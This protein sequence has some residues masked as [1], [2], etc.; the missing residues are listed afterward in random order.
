ML[1]CFCLLH[2]NISSSSGRYQLNKTGEMCFIIG[3]TIIMPSTI[4]L[5]W[6]FTGHTYLSENCL[7][8]IEPL[9]TL[10][11]EFTHWVFL[12]FGFFFLR[13]LWFGLVI[14]RGDN[15][16]CFQRIPSTN[17]DLN[18]LRKELQ[19]MYLLP[20]HCSACQKLCLQCSTGMMP[21]HCVTT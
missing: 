14:L 18:F 21:L 5:K 11:K 13:E 2:F 7:T 15:L 6:I 1:C 10:L 19:S 8:L 16:I 20:A 17:I 9:H 4:P 12:F 3:S